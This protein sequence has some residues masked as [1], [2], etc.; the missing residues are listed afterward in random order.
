MLAL[1]RVL[2]TPA[3]SNTLGTLTE[4]VLYSLTASFATYLNTLADPD[5]ITRARAGGAFTDVFASRVDVPVTTHDREE[6]AGEVLED[7]LAEEY[8]VMPMGNTV[9]DFM[10]DM[11]D[12]IA[13]RAREMAVGEAD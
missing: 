7:M 3:L 2:V 5:L 10:R 11:E 1:G 9:D 13:E 4:P 8:P 12:E 6:D